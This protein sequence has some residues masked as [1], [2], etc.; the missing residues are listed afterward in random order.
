[1]KMNVVQAYARVARV[2]NVDCLFVPL[3]G[4][5]GL[6]STGWPSTR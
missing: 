4:V 5:I 2:T 1:M 6:S 3:N